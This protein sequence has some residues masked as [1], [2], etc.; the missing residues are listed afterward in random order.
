VI[1]EFDEDDE[2][3]IKSIAAGHSHAALCTKSGELYM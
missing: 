3:E 1:D 2:L